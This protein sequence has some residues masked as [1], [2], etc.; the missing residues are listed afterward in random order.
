MNPWEVLSTEEVESI[1][2]A[3]LRVL[4]QVGIVLP[5]NPIRKQLL[6]KG[7]TIKDERILL[8][9]EM[10]ENALASCAKKVTT[11]GRNGQEIVLGDGSLHWH[12]LGGARDIYD[13]ITGQARHA[14]IQDVRDST[15]LLDALN[16]ATTITPFFTPRDVP[17][18][19]MSLAMY[20]HALPFTTKPLQGPG[21]QTALEVKYAVAMA[22][23]IGPVS[24]TLT[25][26][27]SPVSPLAF[28]GDLVDSMVE[29]AHYGIPFG[30]L[31]CPTAGTT[32]PFSLAGALTQQNAEVLASIVI[33]QLVNPGLPIIYC[34]RL[35]MMEPRTGA[36]IW[37]GV[38]LGIA[39]AAT[40]QIGHR[41][42]LP[43]NVYGLSTNAHTLDIQSGYERALNS[44]LPALAGADELSGIGEMEAGVMGSYAQ[45]VCDND[46][47]ASVQRALRGFAVDEDS[48]A[49]DVIGKVMNGSHNYI[50]ER[51]SVKYL[52]S[53]EILFAELGERRT[54]AEWDRTGRNG[55]AEKAQE[56]AE[57]LLAEHQ[58]PPLEDA[59]EREL[60][61]I[62]QAA[63]RELIKA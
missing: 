51:H 38:E 8:P 17:G 12:N 1:H 18:E 30:P 25:M 4:S 54:F 46:I 56:E 55:L 7:A 62:M 45:M 58:V 22:E 19:L 6:D 3:T 14:T 36:S 60:D 63:A 24:K 21:V 2:H 50:A 37:G 10:V 11:V 48:L 57:C 49:V 34:G 9:P 52:R 43:V 61:K 29:I 40:V 47:A 59:Q 41:Y 33:V 44:I 32:A 23:V 13:P 27:V 15:R 39:S 26:S 53:G 28:P 5:H 31:P 42:N 20:R 16:Q 35:A